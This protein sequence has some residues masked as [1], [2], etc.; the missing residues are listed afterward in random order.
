M[1]PA[2]RTVSAVEGADRACERACDVMRGARLGAD[3]A[4][5]LREGGREVERLK[6]SAD[7]EAATGTCDQCVLMRKQ[8]SEAAAAAEA[9]ALQLRAHC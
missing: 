6:A 7:K 3:A 8:C 9:L 2:R 1:P 5:V 4:A